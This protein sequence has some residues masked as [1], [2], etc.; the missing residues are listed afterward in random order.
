MN[1][2]EYIDRMKEMGTPVATVAVALL[3]LFLVFIIIKMLGGMR[4]GSWKQLFRTGTTL[5]AAIISYSVAVMLSNSIMGSTDFESIADLINFMENNFPGSGE[6]LTQTLSTLDSEV[7]EY[8][9]ILPATIVLLPLLC[10]VIFLL[11]NLILQIVRNILIKIFGFT[12]TKSNSRRLGGALL[13]G[14][15]A[16]IWM[17]IVTLPITGILGIADSACEG[18]LD[19]D[20]GQDEELRATYTE[21]IFPF[22]ENPAYTFIDAL[23]SQALSDGIATIELDEVKTN[24]REEILYLTQIGMVE[25]PALEG[26]DFG[27]L[28]EEN[29]LSLNNIT[30]AIDRSPFVA[31]VVAGLV[32]STSGLINGDSLPLDKEGD[33][34]AFFTALLDFLEGVTRGTLAGDIKT[35]TEVYYAISDSGVIKE[36]EECGDADLMAV[37]Q[38]K[39]RAG[40]DTIPEIIAILRK[41]PRTAPLVRAMSEALLSTLSTGVTLP[42]G[43]TVEVS[44]DSLKE[45]MQDVLSVERGDYATEEEYIGAISDSLD[46]TLRDNGITL[47][48]EIIDSIAE[49]IG[50]EYEGAG[51]LTDEQFNDILLNYYDAYLEYVN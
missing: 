26:A 39:Q 22:T 24:L 18:A 42:D 45:D 27:A 14:I 43:T 36:L 8:V 7:F 1:F 32:Q 34:A 29:K 21:Y 35:I 11:I 23:G 17:I 25:I 33:Y 13:G 50:S 19:S 48:G 30:A 5:L 37:L 15:E 49:Y 38:E 12:A 9:I 16:I 4:R 2:F 46:C 20:S 28:T 47:D 41:N 6:I 40:D 31:S 51:E 10:T 44:Y 3:C